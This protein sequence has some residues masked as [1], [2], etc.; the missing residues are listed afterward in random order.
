[1]EGKLVNIDKIKEVAKEKGIKLTYLCKQ[2]NQG[3]W[4]FND[5]SKGKTKISDDDLQIIADILNVS[6]EYLL[7]NTDKKDIIATC[8]SKEDDLKAVLFGGE[9]PSDA[10]W[11]ELKN[12]AEYLK[13]KYKDKK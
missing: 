12:Y 3:P 8:I 13:T 9:K 10:M 5:V 6:V 7:G 1:M 2:V 11:E 4:Y